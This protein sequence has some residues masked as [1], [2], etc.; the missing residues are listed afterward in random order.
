MFRCFDSLEFELKDVSSSTTGFSSRA[1]LGP[2]AT[3]QLASLFCTCELS[4]GLDYINSISRFPCNKR[5]QP[6][7]SLIVP[8]SLNG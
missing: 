3:S 2:E 8:I 4:L 7:T 6:I 5:W 1:N